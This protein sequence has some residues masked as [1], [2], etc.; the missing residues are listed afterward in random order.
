MKL[1]Q[2][3]EPAPRDWRIAEAILAAMV[4]LV[5]GFAAYLG[6][7]QHG[8]DTTRQGQL[9]EMAALVRAMPDVIHT[10]KRCSC[11]SGCRCCSCQE[12]P[13]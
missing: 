7:E 10:P 8:S 4:L 3:P 1:T 12:L 6:G 13:R 9:R 5:V 2:K 11:G